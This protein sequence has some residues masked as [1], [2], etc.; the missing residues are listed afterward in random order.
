M[1]YT[2]I[3]EDIAEELIKRIIKLIP[4][5]PTILE[6]KE[7]WGLLKI[8]GFEIDDL[9]PSLFQCTFALAK[10]QKIYNESTCRKYME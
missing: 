8:D 7:P 6:M 2:K 10:A 1:S 4:D 9:Q 3:Y 5:N